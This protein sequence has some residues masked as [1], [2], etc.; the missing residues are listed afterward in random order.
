MSK[1]IYIKRLEQDLIGPA[2]GHEETINE[3][4]SDKYLSGI[5]YP[6]NT[7]NTEEE[8]N[9]EIGANTNDGEE[10]FNEEIEVMKTYKPSS[11][12]LSFR[13]PVTSK[14]KINVHVKFGKYTHVENKEKEST[15]VRKDNNVPLEIDVTEYKEKTFHVIENVKLHVISNFLKESVSFTISLLNN[16][17]KNENH[18]KIEIEE[19]MLFQAS[20]RIISND[21]FVEKNTYV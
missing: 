2:D 21:G 12:G 16:F 7:K 9:G 17:K 20:I 19:M 13:V 18:T 11:L 14:G 8:D 1:E 5:L 4:P 15:F 6:L 10:S 3:K